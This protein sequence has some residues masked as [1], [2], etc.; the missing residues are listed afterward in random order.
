LGVIGLSGGAVV[1]SAAAL[2]GVVCVAHMATEIVATA[3]GP[4]DLQGTLRR[5][6]LGVERRCVLPLRGEPA[7][8][9]AALKVLR[10][11]PKRRH[12][13]KMFPKCKG[14]RSKLKR[15]QHESTAFF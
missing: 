8:V 7:A 13:R 9:V 2:L 4:R 5:V 1:V 14:R 12:S 11:E 15:Q 10:R 3:E 6:H